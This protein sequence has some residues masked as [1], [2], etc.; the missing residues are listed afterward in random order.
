MDKIEQ[1]L[2]EKIADL[3]KIPSGAFN[4]RKNGQTDTRTSTKDI[5]ISP[6]TDKSGIDIFVNPNVKNKS[7]HI[8]VIITVGGLTDLVYNDFY[9]GENAD[10]LIVAGCGIHNKTCNKSE[11]NGIHTFHI[12][13]N[14]KVKYVEKHVGEGEGSGERVLNPVTKIFMRE[15]S[16]MEMETLQLEGVSSTIRK[17]E[18]KLYQNASLHIQENILTTDSQTAKTLFKVELLGDS[19]SVEVVSHSVARDSSYQ[20]FKSDLIG[21]NH[22][23]GHVECDGILLDNARIVSVPKIDAI[24]SNASLIHE[25]AIGK[26]AGDE[27]NKLMTL[28]LTQ[29]EAENTIIQGFLLG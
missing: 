7:V 13:K 14:A 23:F 4:L 24:D 28:G 11:H 6:K 27:L 18:A 15:N 5:E 20:E 9:I 26:I 19:S 17:T 21:K 12:G 16:F 2:L 1:R 25:A 29:T 8:P 3:H 10:V 22:C